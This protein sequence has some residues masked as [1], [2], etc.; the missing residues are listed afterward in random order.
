M[1]EDKKAKDKF[2]WIGLIIVI[3]SF[4]FVFCVIKKEQGF[5]VVSP[6]NNITPSIFYQASIKPKGTEIRINKDPGALAM[7]VSVLK[8][9]LPIDPN[10]D[11]LSPSIMEINNAETML[12]SVR[13][14]LGEEP[15]EP[16]FIFTENDYREI[17][18]LISLINKD[19]PKVNSRYGIKEIIDV[20]SA[21]CKES[22]YENCFP[23]VRQILRLFLNK[24][25]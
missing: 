14:Y 21:G 22:G 24:I 4:V 11:Y 3:V 20:V 23:Y 8:T 13:I 17:N 10:K 9:F 7:A 18:R 16:L 19:T 25:E 6:R 15:K 2:N 1:S 5:L 12:S